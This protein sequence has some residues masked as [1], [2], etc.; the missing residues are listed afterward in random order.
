[1][2]SILE[3]LIPIRARKATREEIT[4]LHTHTYHDKVF[5][6]NKTGGEAG[7]QA[8]F[9]AHGY[10]I[11]ALSC[12]GVLAAVEAL[13]RGEIDNA[14][15]LIRPPDHHAVANE[16]MGFCIFNNVVIA[17][18]QARSISGGSIKKIA[19]VDYDVHHGNGTQEA[20]WLDPDCLFIS[21]HQDNNYPNGTGRLAE[22]GGPG[23]ERTT[24]NIPLPHGS[25]TGAYAY[26]F[27]RVVVPSLEKFK[28]DLILVSSGFDCSYADPLGAMM[29]SSEGF[30]NMT[31]SLVSAAARLCG[32]KLIF[33]HEGGY[34]KDYVPFCGL[35]VVEA[36]S[37]IKSEV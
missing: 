14:Y 17:A 36:L 10:D 24:I 12:G 18:L 5:S 28:P 2:S 11:A 6:L 13:L 16:G 26:A 3:K 8:R 4:S 25:G 32:G 19:I 30:A 35:A 27:D 22:I 34:S 20:F 7:E 21:L 29:M 9:A 33:V 1:V 37:G 31:N 23:A 15:C